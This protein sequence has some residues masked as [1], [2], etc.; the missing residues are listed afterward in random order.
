M[1]EDLH[2]SEGAGP[3]AL[4][5]PVPPRDMSAA[6]KVRATEFPIVLRGYDRE[7]VDDFMAQVADL[8]DSLEA[9][10]SRETVVQ[11]A[12]EEV[13]EETSA[14]LKQAHESADDITARSRSQAEDR[15]E[16]ARREAA[17][18]TGEARLEADELKRSTRQLQAERASLVEELRRFA[19]DTL[20]VADAA[21]ERMDPGS[22][23]EEPAEPPYGAGEDGAEA[24]V[25]APADPPYDNGEIESVDEWAVEDDEDEG[26]PGSPTE[27]LVMPDDEPTSESPRHQP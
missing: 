23:A 22:P 21:T 8:I 24:L 9:R 4:S 7:A 3:R 12:L 26:D 25:G 13:G 20:A 14:I 6:E 27:E 2:I 1:E 18:I 15:L 5:K 17:A 19:A 10:Q 16:V 11:R